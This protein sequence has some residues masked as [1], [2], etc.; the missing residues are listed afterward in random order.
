MNHSK[1][2]FKAL[3]DYGGWQQTVS[4]IISQLSDHKKFLR[5]FQC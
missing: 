5:F 2:F 1:I 3:N 4:E